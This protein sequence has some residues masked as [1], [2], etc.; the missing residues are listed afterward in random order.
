MS[1]NPPWRLITMCQPWPDLN[2]LCWGQVRLQTFEAT[3]KLY[4]EI[5]SSGSQ[6]PRKQVS[7]RWMF[8]MKDDHIWQTSS[9][10]KGGGCLM[11]IV[12]DIGTRTDTDMCGR[13]RQLM[14]NISHHG[15]V[16]FLVG[17][18]S[19]FS[20][21]K[22]WHVFCSYIPIS[23]QSLPNTLVGLH[24][25]IFRYIS[26]HMGRPRVVV[27]GCEYGTS[28]AHLD[29]LVTNSLHHTQELCFKPLYM[30]RPPWDRHSSTSISM[31]PC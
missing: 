12:S 17:S 30:A 26:T 1:W 19:K 27:K 25:G 21:S 18:L 14:F 20:F 13:L 22:H 31:L 29:V 16:Q 2:Y 24:L 11:D 15:L 8:S 7:Y 10:K 3:L 23:L 5:R 6:P 9:S 28:L 4:D